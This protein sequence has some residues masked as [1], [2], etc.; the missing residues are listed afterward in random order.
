MK[1]STKVL[2]IT[3]GMMAAL[4]L[5][6]CNA[7]DTDTVATV[8]GTQVTVGEA[9]L[10][11]TYQQAQYEQFYSMYLNTTVNWSQ[12]YDGEK[13]MEDQT[14]EGVLE[15]FKKMQIVA[16]HAADY[17]ISISEEE[18]AKIEEAA[19]KLIEANDE[20]AQKAL[21][22][23]KESA[24]SLFETYYLYNK[25][26]EAMVAD[27][28]TEVSDEEAAQKKMSYIEFS[29]AGTTDEEGNTVEL[30]DEE[31][32]EIKTKAE[33]VVAAGA[34]EMENAING[35]DYSVLE[36][37]FDAESDTLDAAVYEA[38]NKLKEGEMSSVIETETAYYVVRLD[39]NFDKEATE[40][41]KES[42][43]EERKTEAFDKVYEG[44][45]TEEDAFVLDEKAWKSIR[46]KD[47]ISLKTEEAE[48]TTEEATV[49]ETGE[50]TEDAA[51]E[52]TG[53]ATED[54]TTETA[55]VT[56]EAGTETTE[57]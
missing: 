16:S 32:A 7:K 34:T 56:P 30:T 57:E 35:T 18:Q 47:K 28:N 2:G 36:A 46:F 29:L 13:T 19:T 23:S 6:G 21:H 22:M 15:Q 3:A 1:K 52:E 40:S 45:E 37:T 9:G 4:V 25:V 5:T 20:K 14:K 8:Y 50:A 11:A 33:A 12:T 27:V 31:K 42:I 38:A 39:S 51:V 10:F 44:W 54:A 41:K 26:S 48:E 24:T 43:V 53:E 17:N 55:E 49:E